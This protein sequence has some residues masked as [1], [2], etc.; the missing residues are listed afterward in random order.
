MFSPPP[1]TCVLHLKNHY[2]KYILPFF[3]LYSIETNALNTKTLCILLHFVLHFIAFS[4]AF[5]SILVCVLL[6]F[7]VY[8]AAN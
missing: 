1:I 4:L 5:C 6:H 8:F 2:L 7:A 3:A